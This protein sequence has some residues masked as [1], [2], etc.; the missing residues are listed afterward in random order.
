MK[1][2]FGKL[3]KYL[4]DSDYRFLFNA[5]HGAYRDMPDKEYL[6]RLYLAKLKKRLDLDNPTTFNE[7][8]QWLKLYDR[9][10]EYCMMVDKYEVKQYVSEKLSPS[11]VIPTIGLWNTVEEIDFDSL[12]E[13]FVIK[14]THDSH[15]LVVCRDKSKLNISA[16]KKALK[17][18]LK[19]NYFHIYREWPYRD[20]KPRII[21]EEYLEDS[22]TKDLRDYK[23]FCFNGKARFYKVDFDRFIDHHANYYDI[24]GN[25]L[26]FGEEVCPPLF[27]RKL[28]MPSTIQKMIGYA[29]K[30]AEG[31]TFMRV[32]FYDVDGRI[33]FGEITFF[34]AAGFGVISPSEWD[35]KI[36]DMMQLPIQKRA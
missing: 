25:M 9:N 20:V 6:E 30:L 23:F 31:S 24:D 12:P 29:E 2:V 32:D 16:A 27:D 15:G 26:Y 11:V 22:T 5:I 10:R 18:A 14:C 35:T 1:S 3:K 13:R 21:V 4:F 36:G 19:R 8:L 33:Y 28:E 17:K 7:K 34:P